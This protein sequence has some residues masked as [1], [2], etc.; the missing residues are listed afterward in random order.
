MPRNLSPQS[1]TVRRRITLHAAIRQGR[2]S[3][4]LPESIGPA[5]PRLRA[6][7]AKRN[8]L[9]VQFPG[10]AVAGTPA[11][12]GATPHRLQLGAE[13][14]LTRPHSAHFQDAIVKVR[15]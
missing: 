14:K 12:I 7:G 13:A 15:F 9:P 1:E 10:G 3:W 8:R 6:A 2:I 11:L 4:S 5:I